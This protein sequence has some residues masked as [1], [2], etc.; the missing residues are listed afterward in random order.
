MRRFG[1]AVVVFGAALA[2]GSVRE[3]SS[4]TLLWGNY[5][6]PDSDTMRLLNE[7]HLDGIIDA[8]VSYNIFLQK[9]NDEML[10]CLPDESVFTVRQ[11]EEI[12]ASM[13]N[14]LSNP[15]DV[16]ISLLLIIGLQEQF[17]CP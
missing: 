3:G 8:I 5:K 9:T 11:A 16:P 13:A 4:A 10:F 1:W 6:S 15:D 7:R 17:A 12:I 14:R 2:F